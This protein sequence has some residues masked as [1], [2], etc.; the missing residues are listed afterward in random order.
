MSSTAKGAQVC[1]GLLVL[2]EA[3]ITHM[4][5]CGD[6]RLKARFKSLVKRNE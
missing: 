4:W 1:R 5:M 6:S 3:R 2:N